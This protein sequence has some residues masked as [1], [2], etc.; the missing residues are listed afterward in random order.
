MRPHK[1]LTALCSAL[2]LV[3]S[4]VSGREVTAILEKGTCRLTGSRL[5]HWLQMRGKHWMTGNF[6]TFR[7]FRRIWEFKIFRGANQISPSYMSCSHYFPTRV[8]G[9][10]AML[11]SLTSLDLRLFWWL[12]WA[13]AFPALPLQGMK[14]SSYAIKGALWLSHLAFSHS[15]PISLFLQLLWSPYFIWYIPTASMFSSSSI[16]SLFTNDKIFSSWT[17]RSSFPAVR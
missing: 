1:S 5:L 16:I 8:F 6:C 10:L 3:I 12:S 13:S 11:G 9:R 15:D 7:R 4:L 14:P 2:T 17:T